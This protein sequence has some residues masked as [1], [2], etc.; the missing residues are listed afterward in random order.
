MRTVFEAGER[1][2]PVAVKPD[3]SS[4]IPEGLPRAV[5][6]V[7]ACVILLAALPFLALAAIA[8]ALD[9]KGPVLFRQ[10]RVGRGGK[11]YTL[12][13]LR[14]MRVDA[15]G[16]GVTAHD[17]PRVT[18]VG[19]L[20]RRMKLD[21][22][23]QLWNV[24]LGDMSLVGPRPEVP[25]YV[26][27]NDPLWQRV[28][29]VRP[30]VTDPATLRLLDE[31]VVLANAKEDRDVYYQEQLLPLK[32]RECLAHLERRS[33]KSDV[34]ALLRTG[35][36][37]L[38]LSWTGGEPWVSSA[39]AARGGPSRRAAQPTTGRHPRGYLTVRVIQFLLDFSVLVGAFVYAYLLRF[40]FRVPPAEVANCLRQLPLVV[41]VQFSILILAGVHRFIWR[42]VGLRDARTVLFA[43]IACG[44]PALAMRIALPDALARWRVPLS[45][46]V[47]DTMVVFIGVLGLRLSRRTL[48]EYREKRSRSSQAVGKVEK[49]ALLVG[50]G[51]AGV[52]AA[53]E[54]DGQDDIGLEVVGFVDDDLS[55]VG[56][57]INSFR[58]L[59]T[60]EDLPRLVRERGI[61]QVVITIARITRPD[62]LRIIDICRKIPVQLRVVPGL[63]EI[64]Q[65]KVQTTRLRIVDVENL[66]AREP[67][68][69]DEEQIGRFLKGKTVMITGAGG[70]IGTELSRQVARFRPARLLLVERAEAALFEIDQDV[71]RL[72]P[73][74]PLVPLVCD[75][76]QESRVRA[77][78]QE[79]RPDVVLH[80]AAHK[81]VPMMESHPGEAVRNNVLATRLLGETA[82]RFGVESFVLISTDKAVN[83]TSVMGA[84][85]RMAEIVVQ[86]LALRYPGRFLAV[87]FGNVIGSAG[88]VVPVFREQIRRGGPVTV[89]HPEMR[90][91]FMTVREASQLVL[92]AGAM[93]DGGEIFVLDMGDPVRILDL[94]ISMIR[95]SG[96]K[97]FED[98]DIVFTGLRPGEKLFEELEM[99]GEE[100]S[101]TRHPR[102][103]IGRLQG[104]APERVQW[105]LSRLTALVRDGKRIE[106]RRFLNAFLPEARLSV[107]IAAHEEARSVAR[108]AEP[109]P[110]SSFH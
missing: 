23:P 62:I 73:A 60:T 88:S 76:G 41:L 93:G 103:F 57:V 100:I 2:R 48:F 26:D 80:A 98:M 96:L 49:R 8:I 95:L 4:P 67:A 18:R 58:V 15:R 50:A 35:L 105:A 71:R 14:T 21:E 45:V 92:Q 81:H 40:D 6:I 39:R 52:L 94:A 33:W 74:V 84:S 87:R 65:G 77:I 85:K 89:T 44:L 83:P 55:K 1:R 25:R 16:A 61:D 32:L 82:G 34:A 72:F 46:V 107:P 24:L 75:V 97:P 20:L 78:F 68:Q 86:D 109:E 11:R 42:Y 36:D 31:E 51:R 22:V 106:I 10:E 99:S 37:L 17:D 30:G 108:P 12:F 19:R 66:L 27:L 63:F 29:S 47:I 91:Y 3:P 28:L 64:L 9:S 38:L 101:K 90:R 79:H 110:L 54:I 102:I 59:G 70:S 13:K 69:L 56:A 43:S 53:R 7:L 5:E 104:Y